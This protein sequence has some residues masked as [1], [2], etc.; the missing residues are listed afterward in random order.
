MAF[1][2]GNEMEYVHHLCIVLELVVVYIQTW[3]LL[4][5]F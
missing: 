3:I 5:C 4:R 1:V 2:F